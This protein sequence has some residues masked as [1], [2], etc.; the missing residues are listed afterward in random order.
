MIRATCPTC[1][2]K[3]GVPLT[4]SVDGGD[5]AVESRQ[6]QS[7]GSDLT[8]EQRTEKVRV[9]VEAIMRKTGAPKVEAFT[10]A[11]ALMMPV[12]ISTGRP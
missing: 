5:L 3:R 1:R 8:D 10:R 12:C 7:C 2:Q 6:C 11:L 9:L 4:L